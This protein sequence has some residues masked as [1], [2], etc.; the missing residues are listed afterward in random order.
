MLWCHCP[1]CII[2]NSIGGY[3]SSLVL[4][5]GYYTIGECS[6]F[7]LHHSAACMMRGVNKLY[8]VLEGTDACSVMT[9]WLIIVLVWSGDW[10]NH[11]S[12]HGMVSFL[13]S[14]GFC[15][16]TMELACFNSYYHH[17]ANPVLLWLRMLPW[18]I[19]SILVTWVTCMWCIV[20][21]AMFKL[22]FQFAESLPFCCCL[23]RSL[24]GYL[25]VNALNFKYLNN[26][27]T[28]Q[29]L[30]AATCGVICMAIMDLVL[31]A[32]NVDHVASGWICCL[33]Y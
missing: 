18:K 8:L 32:I 7:L 17:R 30:P 31:H 26:G 33:E 29:V 16:G 3:C 2:S 1:F 24:T 27:V 12:N 11:K 25:M 9:Y 22:L 28:S 23:S 20:S 15:R 5:L 10:L 19:Q 21:I 6:A 13:P 4:H 14:S